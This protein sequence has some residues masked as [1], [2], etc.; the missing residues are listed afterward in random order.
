MGQNPA[1]DS[2]P[3]STLL[4]VIKHAAHSCRAHRFERKIV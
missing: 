2:P 4:M 3:L 1:A